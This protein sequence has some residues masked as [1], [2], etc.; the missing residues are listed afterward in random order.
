[1]KRNWPLPP[2]YKANLADLK[3]LQ[4]DLNVKKG[5]YNFKF[6]KESK[7]QKADIVAELTELREQ[8]GDYNPPQY[9]PK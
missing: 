3:Y 1:M 2:N 5:E 8:I 4:M 7:E 6:L 9:E